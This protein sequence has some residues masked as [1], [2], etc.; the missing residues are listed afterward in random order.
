MYVPTILH[1][2]FST[3]YGNSQLSC[4]RTGAGF[5]IFPVPVLVQ[6]R[7]QKTVPYTASGHVMEILNYL[8][9]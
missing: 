9:K 6:E 4:T 2:S 8:D 3:C 7:V 5:M 1:I